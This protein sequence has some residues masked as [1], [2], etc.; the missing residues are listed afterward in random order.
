MMGHGNERDGMQDGAIASRRL[1]TRIFDHIER[2]QGMHNADAVIAELTHF[3]DESG[4][5]F[6]SFW[7][8]ANTPAAL[9]NSVLTDRPHYEWMETIFERGQAEGN[10]VMNGTLGKN[11]P[12]SWTEMVRL[13][14]HGGRLL[15]IVQAA[16]DFGINEGLSFGIQHRTRPYICAVFYG[17][18]VDT[19]ADTRIA[20]HALGLF[21]HERLV[22]LGVWPQ[23]AGATLTQREADCLSWVA[24]GK[25]DWEISEILGISE[26]TVHWYIER[27]KA[28]FGVPTRVQV[29]VRAIHDR[30]IHI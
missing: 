13:P 11:G 6:F 10:P 30:E 25:T 17:S 9:R 4:I 18:R 3:L 1:G 2:I 20:L 22:Q 15:P 5:D 16:Q 24:N 7:Q 27:A 14:R 28:K 8:P 12:L 23:E 29:V 19:S 26:N 21:T